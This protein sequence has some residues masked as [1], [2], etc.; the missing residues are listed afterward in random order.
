MLPGAPVGL[1]S[2][3]SAG[4]SHL[5]SLLPV[6]EYVEIIRVIRSDFQVA[7]LTHDVAGVNFWCGD[8][9]R[10]YWVVDFSFREN[11]IFRGN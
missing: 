10:E 6:Q 5:Q 9:V 7:I 8:F 4:P 1:V 2:H 3:L 11:I